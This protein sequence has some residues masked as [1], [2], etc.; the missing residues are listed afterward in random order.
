ME[1]VFGLLIGGV[2]G[3]LVWSFL[4]A[5]ILRWRARKLRGW[6]IR[7]RDAYVVS[8]KA[9][10]LALIFGELAAFAVLFTG[11]NDAEVLKSVGMVFGLV[12][13]WFAHSN[14]LLKLAGPSSLLSPQ[15]ARALSAS[16]FGYL[17]GGIFCFALGILLLALLYAA[18][19]G[20]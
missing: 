14:A 18:L 7:Y 15:D 3:V 4:N 5:G 17:F 6:E 8:I 11:N 12:T 19:F 16:V 1:Y 2:I 20:K 9:G 10:F 13:W